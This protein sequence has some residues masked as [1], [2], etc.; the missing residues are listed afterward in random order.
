MNRKELLKSKEYWLVD[1]QMKLYREVENYL[2]DSNLNKSQFAN[3]LGVSKGYISQILNGDFDHKLSKLIELSLAINKVPILSFED[4]NDYFET[5]RNTHLKIS[6]SL[7]EA[8]FAH[9]KSEDTEIIST[10]AFNDYSG[11]SF[12]YEHSGM[13]YYSAANSEI[14]N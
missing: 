13:N 3:Q 5:D 11:E 14:L 8:L 6:L 12:K 7:E 2:S 10:N 9:I 1:F 4:F